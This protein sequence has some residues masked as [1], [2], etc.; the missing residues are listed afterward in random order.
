MKKLLMFVT[1]AMFVSLIGCGDE[2]YAHDC[3]NGS[4]Y[5]GCETSEDAN[6]CEQ[7]DMDVCE[8]NPLYDEDICDR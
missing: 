4:L 1:L 2:D 8:R 5:Y 3:C 7:G 6:A